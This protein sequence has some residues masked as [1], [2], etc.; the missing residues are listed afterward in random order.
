MAVGKVVK[1]DLQKIPPPP[2]PQ[3]PYILSTVGVPW[4]NSDPMIC[5]RVSRATDECSCAFNQATIDGGS[6]QTYP[7]AIP[8]AVKGFTFTG[9]VDDHI[10]SDCRLAKIDNADYPFIVI[11]DLSDQELADAPLNP[12]YAR[13]MQDLCHDRFGVNLVLKAPVRLLETPGTCKDTG[14]FCREYTNITAAAAPAI[15]AGETTTST[16][17][18]TNSAPPPPAP[19]AP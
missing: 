17:N 12:K 5:S 2:Y 18:R 15:P 4:R 13:S 19:V 11:C 6:G 1:Y 9:W 8:D 3:V 7:V 10:P 16:S 14:A